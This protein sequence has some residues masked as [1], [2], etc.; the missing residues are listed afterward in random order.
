MA[1]AISVL[2]TIFS[3]LE[4]IVMVLLGKISGIFWS[5]HLFKTLFCPWLFS[6]ALMFTAHS[7]VTLAQADERSVESSQTDQINQQ[8]IE[9]NS[10]K[11]RLN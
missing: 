6:S 2:L 8:M 7:G 11:S 4:S 9:P 10:M 5:L 1:V 3:C